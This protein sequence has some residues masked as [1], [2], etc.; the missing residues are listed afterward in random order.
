MNAISHVA[1]VLPIPERGPNR[2]QNLKRKN[3]NA[4]RP[5][6]AGNSR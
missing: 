1:I 2:R 5:V 3:K 6:G 4:A